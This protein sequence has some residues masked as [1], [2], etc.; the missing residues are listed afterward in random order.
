MSIN[1]PGG[2]LGRSQAC[3][4]AL[5]L[6]G[7]KAVTDAVL[8]EWLDR[9]VTR[10][11][12]LS[13]GR[14]KPIPHESFFLVAG[15]F[16]YF[17]HYYAALSIGQLPAADRPFYQ[18]HLAAILLQLQE[19]D[20]SWWD[21]PLYNYHKPYGTAFALMSLAACRHAPGGPHQPARVAP[22]TVR[23]VSGT[24]PPSAP[25]DRSSGSTGS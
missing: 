19:A 6:W 10:N 9:L 14:K 4:L 11:G 25:S 15:Y 3:H 20:G 13:M 1:Q 2:S 16:F 24:P 22:G 23:P 5:R 7:D 21:Y 18:D 8:K 12:W 17:G